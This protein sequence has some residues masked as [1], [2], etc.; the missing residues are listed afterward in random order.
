MRMTESRIFRFP[1]IKDFLDK[2]VQFLYIF[3]KDWSVF[4]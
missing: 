2:P 4:F 3:P 1:E